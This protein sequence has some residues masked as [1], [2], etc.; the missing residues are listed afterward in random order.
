MAVGEKEISIFW[1]SVNFV[2]YKLFSL[3][4]FLLPTINFIKLACLFVW[5]LSH[6]HS[7]IVF[8]TAA[9]SIGSH[10]LH[11]GWG[12]GAPAIVSCAH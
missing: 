1:D 2:I 4:H 7:Q 6:A 12:G 10:F 5:I 11:V 3:C 9:L 8:M